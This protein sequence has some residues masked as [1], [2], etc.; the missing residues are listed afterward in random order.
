MSLLPSSKGQAPLHSWG[1]HHSK[2]SLAFILLNNPSNMPNQGLGL[3]HTLPL[4]PLHHQERIALT[5]HVHF[6]F[7]LQICKSEC[8]GPTFAWKYAKK[9][10]QWYYVDLG[11]ECSICHGIRGHGWRRRV[12]MSWSCSSYIISSVKSTSNSWMKVS[13][14]ESRMYK[15]G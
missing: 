6:L 4:C 8:F 7:C 9:P 1:N 14:V 10:L 5:H 11:P 13:R 12:S 2:G 3:T 15:V